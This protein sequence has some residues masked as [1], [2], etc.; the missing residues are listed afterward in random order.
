[1]VRGFGIGNKVISLANTPARGDYTT[2]N[3]RVIATFKPV[4]IN[5]SPAVQIMERLIVLSKI[6]SKPMFIVKLMFYE[7]NN[8]YCFIY[9]LSCYTCNKT[10][11]WR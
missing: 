3:F 11:V 10:C 4:I 6:M 9:H 1:M 8:G 5:W 2:I 7:K